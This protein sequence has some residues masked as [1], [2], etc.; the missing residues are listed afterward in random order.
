MTAG[1]GVATS[2]VMRGQF[3]QL[4]F[5]FYNTFHTNMKSKRNRQCRVELTN[6]SNKT[7]KYKNN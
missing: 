1:T 6:I 5:Y 4:R 3:T 7:I 2:Y